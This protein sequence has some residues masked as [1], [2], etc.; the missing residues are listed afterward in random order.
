MN[1][2]QR[3]KYIMEQLEMMYPDADCSLALSGSTQLYGSNTIGSQ[4]TECSR[5]LSYKG[6]LQEIQDSAIMRM[7]T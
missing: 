5:E 4:C 6:A 3:A 7:Q 2:K 1:K